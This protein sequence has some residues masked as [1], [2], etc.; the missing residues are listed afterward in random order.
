MLAPVQP[1]PNYEDL[2]ELLPFLIPHTPKKNANTLVNYLK[3]TN[4]QRQKDNSPPWLYYALGVPTIV[5]CWVIAFIASSVYIDYAINAAGKNH[6]IRAGLNVGGALLINTVLSYFFEYLG[7]MPTIKKFSESIP[8]DVRQAEDDLENLAPGLAAKVFRGV[9]AVGIV[10]IIL[11]PAIA[12]AF[13]MYALDKKEGN[14]SEF[15]SVIVLLASVFLMYASAKSVFFSLV[16][17][18]WSPFAALHRKLSPTAKKDYEIAIALGAFKAAHRSAFESAR[19]EFLKRLQQQDT[20]SLSPL[21]NLFKKTNESLHAN[22]R[23][24]FQLTYKFLMLAG[25]GYESNTKLRRVFQ[26]LS[27]PITTLSVWGLIKVT[28]DG[29][30]YVFNKYL[31]MKLS[32]GEAWGITIP[33]FLISVA[34]AYDVSWDVTGQ[35]YE[36][37][38]YAFHGIKEAWKNSAS[39]KDFFSFAK[40]HISD[41]SA[42]YNLVKLP[43]AFIQNP[44]TMII[45]NTL[46]LGLCY[47]STQTSTSINPSWMFV[48]TVFAVMQFNFNPF[49]WV[50]SEAQTSVKHITGTQEEKDVIRAEKFLDARLNSI[51]SMDN[52]KFIQ[53]LR[54]FLQPGRL[55]PG[56]QEVLLRLFCGKKSPGEI[57]DRYPFTDVDLREI[58]KHIPDGN[59]NRLRILGFFKGTSLSP[60]ERLAERNALLEIEEGG[61]TCA[62]TETTPL[63]RLTGLRDPSPAAQISI[64][65]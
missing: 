2:E 26:I 10:M 50:T 13:Q 30:I 27:L 52:I 33:D 62:E 15:R 43:R 5:A 39:T 46:I 21:I 16:P 41:M 40:D 12:A 59:L 54:G 31:D 29:V 36:R 47:F 20:A 19:E 18:L 22:L 7:L 35:M 65:L 24:A 55:S 6:P 1:Q 9:I 48:P 60:E 58:V 63:L 49:P 37:A 61:I 14:H 53:V 32:K 25:E 56:Q 3:V 4:Y 17:T 42:W 28:K 45:L 38:E 57:F 64:E 11:L 51:D 44:K 34:I 8:D 23:D